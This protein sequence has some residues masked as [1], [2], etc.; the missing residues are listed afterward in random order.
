MNN[1][2]LN[3]IGEKTNP[4]FW[5]GVAGVTSVINT[6][7]PVTSE[8]MLIMTFILAFAFVSLP[9]IWPELYGDSA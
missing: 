4:G 8:P 9:V 6:I 3:Y 2:L 5:I 7:S 1:D